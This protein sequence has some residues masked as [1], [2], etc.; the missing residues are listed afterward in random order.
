[1]YIISS[2]CNENDELVLDAVLISGT[3]Y[4][5]GLKHVSGNFVVIMDADLSHYLTCTMQCCSSLTIMLR[6]SKMQPIQVQ[7]KGHVNDV[8]KYVLFPQPKY[9][10]SLMETGGSIVTET[11]YVKGGGLHGWNLKRKLTR[12]GGNV[13]ALTLL[14]PA[15]SDLNGSFRFTELHKKSVLEDAISTCV[16]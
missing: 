11:S 6:I 5:H 9:L 12:R 8:T 10:P 4:V 1:M 7:I 14:W 13:L 15:L 3:P 2:I 16:S